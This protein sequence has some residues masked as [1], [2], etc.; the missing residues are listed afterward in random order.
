MFCII[1]E[2]DED[3]DPHKSDTTLLLPIRTEDLINLGFFEVE[4]RDR[5]VRAF[6]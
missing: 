3:P 5:T 2:E 4:A 6:L 1:F